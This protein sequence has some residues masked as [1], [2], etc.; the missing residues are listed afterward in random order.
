VSEGEAVYGH[1]L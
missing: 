1:V